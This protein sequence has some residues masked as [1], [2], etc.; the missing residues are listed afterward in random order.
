VARGI[1]G[2]WRLLLVHGGPLRDAQADV[3]V[4]GGR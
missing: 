1:G 3:R 4:R 2:I